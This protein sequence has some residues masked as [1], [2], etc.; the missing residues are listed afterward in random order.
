MLKV[1][2]SY[3]NKQLRTSNRVH[4]YPMYHCDSDGCNCVADVVLQ[5]LR[6]HLKS[7]V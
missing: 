3:I 7:T 6:G 5:F 2:A 4:V 1:V